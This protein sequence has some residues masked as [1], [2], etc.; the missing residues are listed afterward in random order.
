L[1]FSDYAVVVQAALLGQGIALGWLTVAAHWLLTGALV[2]A[3][4]TL[5][6][7]RR[8]CE[9]VHPHDRSIRPVV[10]EIR[11]WIIEQMHTDMAAIDRLY[12]R[13]RLMPASY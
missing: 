8:L 4:E 12:P 1:S 3:S 6:T 7:T 10:S 9:L 5:T 13:L 2:P 11:D